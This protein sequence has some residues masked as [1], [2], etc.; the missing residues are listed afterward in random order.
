MKICIINDVICMKANPYES[1]NAVEA[2]RDQMWSISIT[3]ELKPKLRETGKSAL[4][5]RYFVPKSN[6]NFETQNLLVFS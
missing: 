3:D 2:N 5:I 4:R 1:G 6:E